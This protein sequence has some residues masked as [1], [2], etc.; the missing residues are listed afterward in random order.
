MRPIR[1]IPE[2]TPSVTKLL[3][4][5]LREVSVLVLVFGALD[6][7]RGSEALI[8]AASSFLG[9]ILAERFRR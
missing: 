4:D 8:L 5:S 9:A 2:S 6:G 1:P 7:V 3:S